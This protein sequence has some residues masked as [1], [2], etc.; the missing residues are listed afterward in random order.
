LQVLNTFISEWQFNSSKH[1][2]I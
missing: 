1:V 2:V